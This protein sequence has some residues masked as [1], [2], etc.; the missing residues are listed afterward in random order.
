[1]RMESH[2]SES[3][4]KNFQRVAEQIARDEKFLSWRTVDDSKPFW[5]S[6]DFQPDHLLYALKGV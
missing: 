5:L 6:K 4:L 2:F 1:M 3:D